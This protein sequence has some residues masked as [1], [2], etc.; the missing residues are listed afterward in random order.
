MYT[1]GMS[2]ANENSTRRSLIK[3]ALASTAVLLGR[4]TPSVLAEDFRP[5]V[6]PTISPRTAQDEFPTE[7]E[8][9]ELTSWADNHGINLKGTNKPVFFWTA[10]DYKVDDEDIGLNQIKGIQ[11]VYKGLSILPDDVLEVMRGKTIYM[12]TNASARSVFVNE[13]PD[14]GLS[15]GIMLTPGLTDTQSTLHEFGHLFDAYGL[16]GGEV[17]NNNKN[18]KK[19]P[20]FSDHVDE[21]RQLFTTKEIKP[22]LGGGYQ[23]IAPPGYIS[24]YSTVS[25][26]ENFAEHFSYYVTEGEMF[27]K[28]AENDPLIAEKYN[29]LKNEIFNLKEY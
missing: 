9:T 6:E 15:A 4:P 21:Y 8:L 27:R 24:G 10:L 14:H 12:T 20:Q 3:R 18:P 29:F 5:P 11:E 25:I 22:L 1:N 16:T 7:H 2:E 13:D 17:E 26:Y 19:F 28:K 23:G